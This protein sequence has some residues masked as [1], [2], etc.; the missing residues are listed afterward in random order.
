MAPLTILLISQ[1]CDGQEPCARCVSRGGL[2]CEY[3]VPVHIRKEDMRREIRELR[4]YRRLSEKIFES[5]AIEG[6]SDLIIH[7]LQKRER[8][9]DI[10]EQLSECSPIS[11][12]LEHGHS[13]QSESPRSDGTTGSSS[14]GFDEAHM[15]NFKHGSR[16]TDLTLSDTVIEH[17]LLLYFCWEYP[18]FSSISKRHFVK[19]FNNGQGRYCSSLLVNAILAVGCRF[20]DQIGARTDPVDSDTAGMQCY[21][22][23][24][25]LLA[26][27]CQERSVTVVQAMG[28]MSTWNAS[29]GDYRKARFY[30][31]QS[32]RMAL[33]VGL[34]QEQ[35]VNE[36]SE[37]TLEVRNIA[38]WGA[39]MLDQ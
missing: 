10:Y 33:E 16:W 38:F 31:G 5:L 1:Q 35:G 4:K 28:L 9:E 39:F 3:E 26:T 37:D 11:R 24:E 32:I 19:D 12:T 6:Q 34:H 23:A 20:S 22:E 29:R 30:A 8:L 27:C 25:R 14:P 2:I 18:I 13:S 21:A 17:L 15:D 7:K 36:M